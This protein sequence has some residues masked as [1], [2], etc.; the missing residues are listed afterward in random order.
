MAVGRA[1]V[2][3]TCWGKRSSSRNGSG[4]ISIGGPPSTSRDSKDVPPRHEN[5]QVQLQVF[6]G[7]GVKRRAR[8]RVSSERTRCPAPPGNAGGSQ[9]A[10]EKRASRQ[11]AGTETGEVPVRPILNQLAG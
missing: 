11:G 9:P 1:G 7:L 5:M 8:Q 2:P 4:R 10:A 6:L 3:K